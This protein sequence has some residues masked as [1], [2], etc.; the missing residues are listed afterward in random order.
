MNVAEFIAE[1][2]IGLGIRHVFGVGGANIE[3]LFA[4]IQRRRPAIRAVLAKHEHGAGTAADAYARVSGGLGV[5]MTTSGGGAMNLVHA[6]AEARASRTPLLAIVGEP[7]TP[8]QGKGAFQDTSGKDGT[9]DA[10]QV[11]Q[12]VAGFVARLEDPDDLPAVWQHALAAAQ[13]SPAGPAVLLIAKDRQTAELRAAPDGRSQT[14]PGAPMLAPDVA[15]IARLAGGLRG[16]S[17]L[18]IAGTEAAREQERAALA[19]V[20]DRLP[21]RVAVAPDARDAFDNGDQR[22]CGV[23]GAMGHASVVQALTEAEVVLLA[24]TRMP[25]LARMGLEPLLANKTIV[26]VGAE[27]PYLSG[28]EL[29]HLG[30]SMRVVLEALAEQLGPVVE[31]GVI[32][33]RAARP[34]S[35]ADKLQAASVLSALQDALPPGATV[36]IDAGNAGASTVH[37]LAPARGGRWLLAMGMAGMGYAFG[38]AIGVALATGRRCVVVAGDGAFFMHGLEIHTA[39]EQDLPI[40]YL[41]LNNRAHGMCLIRER[42]LL[43][44]DGGYNQFGV[45]HLGAGLAAMFPRLPAW[46]C[47]D[48]DALASALAQA[49]AHPGPA[50][51]TAELPEVEVPPFVAF[52]QPGAAASS[53]GRA[54]S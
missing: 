17:V 43:G 3:D 40:T 39:L 4:A 7:P 37:F 22:F 31:R 6:L 32:A 18:V 47:R 54:P 29:I 26:S 1:R 51:V 25:L 23:A 41:L 20:V 15:A 11:F 30:G 14:E 5:V 8:H 35:G 44:Q 52:Q 28:R 9:V 46:D 36:V 48:G 45:S 10:A 53:R 19:R 34:A 33:E 24:G 16:R 49:F 38:A 50:V 21:A 13:G 2:L 42:L 12:A 27:P